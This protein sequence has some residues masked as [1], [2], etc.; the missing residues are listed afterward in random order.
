MASLKEQ[1]R[2][3]RQ[4][5]QKALYG[6]RKT[7]QREQAKVNALDNRETGIIAE[8]NAYL[9]QAKEQPAKAAFWREKAEAL[10]SQV[11]EIRE[12]LAKARERLEGPKAKFEATEAALA[13]LGVK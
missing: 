1:K 3:L 8:R 5:L 10:D 9:R 2:I 7:Y 6:Y 4:K 12:Q 13:K 11:S